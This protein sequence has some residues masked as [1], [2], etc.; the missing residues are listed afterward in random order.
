MNSNHIQL[1]RIKLQRF[2]GDIRRY[3]EFK[4]D[5]KQQVEP[6]C[7]M[8]Q[9]AFV[10][11]HYLS[12]EMREG[13]SNVSYDYRA[14]WRRLDQKYGNVR[15]LVEMHLA[16]VK[17]IS[18]NDTSDESIL[19]MINVVERAHRNLQRLGQ[20]NE[21]YNLKT[22]SIIEQAMNKEMSNEWIRT[23][24][25][26]SCSSIDGFL[27]LLDFLTMWRDRLEY[28][29]SAIR[30]PKETKDNSRTGHSHFV[31]SN[32]QRDNG[33]KHPC[34]LHKAGNEEDTHPIW[35]CKRFLEMDTKERREVAMKNKACLRCLLTT[36]AGAT[37]I[38]KC[39]RSFKCPVY[40]C[41]EL[42]NKLLHM[43]QNKSDR[44]VASL[45]VSEFRESEASDTIL[46][47]QKLRLA[48]QKGAAKEVNVLWDGGSQLS[49]ITFKTARRLQ[50]NGKNVKLGLSGVLDKS[51]SIDSRLYQL[52][53]LTPQGNKHVIEAFGV[54]KISSVID[55]V[56]VGGI[57][58]LFNVSAEEIMRPQGG[59]IEVL[60]GLEVAGLHPMRIEAKDNLLLMQNVFG[61]VVSGS[62]MLIKSEDQISQACLQ[63][64]NAVVLNS[65]EK[66]IERFFEVESIGVNCDMKCGACKCGQCQPGGK[67]MSLQDEAEYNMIEKGIIFD[68]NRKRWVASYP[69]T[70]SPERLPN[71][72]H[73]A[74]ATMKSTE[75]RLMKD[76]NHADLYNKQIEDMVERG[77]ARKIALEELNNYKGPVY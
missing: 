62:H 20:H 19:K 18:P 73:I 46:P 76:P 28:Q 69:W 3:P 54:E 14:M 39:Y 13:V 23:V 45:H 48:D 43:D 33:K 5:F 37:N 70:T 34:W 57:A 44:Q 35:V 49:L 17:G 56:D 8:S 32:N 55:K 74:V 25:R 63:V 9:R 11:K 64:R 4:E 51:S 72:R 53:V 67:N 41:R 71:N 16:E 31:E 22:I 75:R 42:H 26:T 50:L 10:L 29:N 36:C 27:V 65:V 52:Q 7:S 68:Q 2:A 1:E 15:R 77:A 21:L 30:G 47:M 59:E 38:E 61:K 6:K 60:I 58:K 24:T 66:G 40:G 12:D